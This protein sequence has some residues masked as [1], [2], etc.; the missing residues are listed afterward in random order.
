MIELFDPGGDPYTFGWRDG[1]DILIMAVLIYQ[2]GLLIR[3][4]RALQML[5]GVMLVVLA[6]WATAPDQPLRMLTLHRVLG[7]ALFYAPFALIILF[8]SPIR[9]AL[10]RLGRPP[11]FGFAP[12][13]MSGRMLDDIV[14]ASADLAERRT[15]ALIVIENDQALKDQVQ[16]GIRLDAAITYDL[17]MT[18]FAPGAPLHDGAAILG[19][20]RVKAA[21]CFLAVTTN[22]QLSRQ[23][24]SRHRAAIGLTEEYDSLVVVVSEERGEIRLAQEGRL[25]PP[26]DGGE[27]RRLLGE[28]LGVRQPR[29]GQAR[30][31]GNVVEPPGTARSGVGR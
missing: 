24:G 7:H 11:M 19:D 15:G 20:G 29:S 26:L 10:A 30:P 2:V 6:Y 8:Q 1:L 16:S 18:I 22:P 27:L 21:S 5:L 4:T 28:R 14:K 12:Q 23:Y 9:R 13:G 25:S 31:D 3:R 17:L